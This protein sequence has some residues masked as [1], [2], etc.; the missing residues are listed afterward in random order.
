MKK[1]L[2][3][4]GLAA[5]FSLTACY[6]SYGLTK[7]IYNWN[8]T[9]GNKWLNSCVHFLMWV[10]PVYPICIGLVDGLVLN[11][12]EFWT[13]SNPIAQGDTYYEKDAQG[14][15]VAA[16]KNADGSLS[17]EITDVQG[18]KANLTLER[19]ADVIRALDANGQVVAQYEVK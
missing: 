18:N 5:A 7:K 19:D 11:T 17:M 8:G 16:V 15:Q 2:I 14:N 3:A 6:G 13:G 9:L 1:G 12:V 4:L 10:I